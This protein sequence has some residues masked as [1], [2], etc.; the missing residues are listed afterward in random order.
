MIILNSWVS[1]WSFNSIKWNSDNLE[2]C[3]HIETDV[4]ELKF[5][6]IEYLLNCLI[7]MLWQVIPVW[8]HGYHT[9]KTLN[10]FYMFLVSIDACISKK[11]L[12]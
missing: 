6:C 3:C 9:V 4:F 1:F 7:N 5:F 10:N 11:Y 12:F 8:I 2:E